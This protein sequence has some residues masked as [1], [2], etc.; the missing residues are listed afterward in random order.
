MEFRCWPMSGYM[1]GIVYDKSQKA[2][3]YSSRSLE[4]INKIKGD[5]GEKIGG[6][7]A[8]P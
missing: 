7:P 2:F 5:K 1:L 4:Q 6:D 3:Y 8:F